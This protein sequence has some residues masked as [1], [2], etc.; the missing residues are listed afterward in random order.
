MRG[1]RLCSTL[2]SF[3]DNWGPIHTHSRN[4]LSLKAILVGKSSSKI[5]DTTSAVTGNIWY[6]SD[7]VEHVSGSE[8]KNGNQADSCPNIAVLENRHKVWPGNTK[9]CHSS[10]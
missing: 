4:N 3:K 5:A 2:V 7:M 10:C 1:D 6:F 9:E 8:E